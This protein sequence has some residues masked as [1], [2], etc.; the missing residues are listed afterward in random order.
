MRTTRTRRL[1]AGAAALIMAAAALP[2]AAAERQSRQEHPSHGGMSAVLRHTEYGIPHVV[3]KDS[4]SLGLGTG[5]AQ[6]ADQVCP[7]ADGFVTVRG[8][9]AIRVYWAPS[10]RR[11]ASL[12]AVRSSCTG[13]TGPSSGVSYDA[14]AAESEGSASWTRV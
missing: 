13:R 2:A 14:I 10:R 1:A 11:A 3:G 12:I 4:K 7:L 5:W 6:A 9:R 8:E